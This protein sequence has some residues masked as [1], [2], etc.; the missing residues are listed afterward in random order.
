M[1]LESGTWEI[2]NILKREHTTEKDNIAKAT[3]TFV[4]HIRRKVFYYFVYL[5]APCVLT[6]ILAILIFYLPAASGERMVVGC[7]I[8][9][10][11]SVF[12]L[13]AT[14]YIPETS[15]HV[16]L[17]GRSVCLLRALL[18]LSFILDN[19]KNGVET[20][21]KSLMLLMLHPCYG[22]IRLPLEPC[23]FTLI[24]QP[25]TSQNSPPPPPPRKF[26]IL[27]ACQFHQ[28]ASLSKSGSL[29]FVICRLVT[30]C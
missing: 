26:S 29:Q 28:V 16:P 30:T 2:I 22:L 25:K 19:Q 10:A 4:V 15:E 14:N 6:A 27:R 17:V 8:L 11:L 20:Q 1:F 12:F 23:N 7:T 5:I 13:L 9:L 24:T 18:K 3:V 21:T